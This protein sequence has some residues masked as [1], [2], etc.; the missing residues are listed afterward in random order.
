MVFGAKVCEN[1]EL[2]S[3]DVVVVPVV[4]VVVELEVVM[5]VVVEVVFVVCDPMVNV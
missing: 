2:D 4:D 1:V 5:L 3:V